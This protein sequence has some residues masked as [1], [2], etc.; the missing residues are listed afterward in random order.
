MSLRIHKRSQTSYQGSILEKSAMER[1]RPNEPAAEDDVRRSTFWKR[2]IGRG[3]R[4]ANVE[5]K[6]ATSAIRVRREGRIVTEIAS[7]KVAPPQNP[8]AMTAKYFHLPAAVDM[9]NDES[10]QTDA[11]GA[12]F[13]GSDEVTLGMRRD[14]KV[15]K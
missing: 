8:D 11:K 12:G 3:V 2:A 6:T 13:R 15:V 7:A 5:A 9:A 1:I 10:N 4:I 14:K